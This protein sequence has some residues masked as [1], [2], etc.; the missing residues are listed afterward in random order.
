MLQNWYQFTNFD[1]TPTSDRIQEIKTLEVMDKLVLEALRYHVMRNSDREYALRADVPMQNQFIGPVTIGPSTHSGSGWC[2]EVTPEMILQRFKVVMNWWHGPR[3]EGDVLD[4]EGEEDVIAMREVIEGAYERWKAGQDGR[5]FAE[6]VRGEDD[7]ETSDFMPSDEDEG[8]FEKIELE[9]GGDDE[10]ADVDF[11]SDE[12][13]DL[14]FEVVMLEEEA[15]IDVEP[16]R[17][18]LENFE[19]DGGR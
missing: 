1:Y 7:D 2:V 17:R 11:E 9:E 18:A 4:D 12:E 10:D 15:K 16:L 13:N 3:K 8:E 6:E 14:E 5:H 19:L